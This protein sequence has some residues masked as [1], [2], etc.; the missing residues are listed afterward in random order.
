[1]AICTRIT[2]VAGGKGAHCC[3]HAFAWTAVCQINMPMLRKMSFKLKFSSKLP[4]NYY[5]LKVM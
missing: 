3:V 5:S 4:L 2:A 1:M